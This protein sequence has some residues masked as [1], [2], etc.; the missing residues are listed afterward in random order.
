MGRSLKTLTRGRRFGYAAAVLLLAAPAEARLHKPDAWA[1]Q[2]YTTADRLR[3]ALNG[4]PAVG[5]SRHEYQRVID[6]YRRVYYGSPAAAKA[7]PSVVAVAELLVEMGRQFDDPKVLRAAI[8]Q[9]QFLRREYPGSRYRFDALFTIGQIYKDDLDDKAKAHEAF[10]EFVRRYP[11]NRLAAQAR[12]ELTE[13]AQLAARKPVSSENLKGSS[14]T[15]APDSSDKAEAKPP[16]QQP[17]GL[18]RVTEI[19]HWSTPDYT[20][21]AI[22]LEQDT[23]FDSQRIDHPDRIFFDLRGTKLASTLVGKSFDVDDGFLKKIR[24]A[25][26]KE[27]RARVVLEVDSLSQYDAFLLP[28]PYRLIVDIHGKTNASKASGSSAKVEAKQ[29][30]EPTPV[31]TQARAKNAAKDPAKGDKAEVTTPAAKSD[32][33]LSTDANED[34]DADVAADPPAKV[35]KD[36]VAKRSVVKN[37]IAINNIAKDTVRKVSNGG[38]KEARTDASSSGAT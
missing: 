26:F 14:K 18:A 6:A 33:S 3:E 15:P 12:E 36:A 9:Y 4:R 23:K 5:R 7:D 20:R 1:R 37:N 32:A 34:D 21:V 31:D 10:Q 8:G 24:V 19:R 16:P 22:D 2:Q 30:P 28:N 38:T 25:Q 35:V 11:H 29:D 27:D 13:P 17:T